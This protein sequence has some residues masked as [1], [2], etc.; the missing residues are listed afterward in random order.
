MRYL[1]FLFVS[2]PVFATES[3]DLSQVLPPNESAYGYSMSDP[4]TDGTIIVQEN[5]GVP[6]YVIVRVPED[7]EFSSHVPG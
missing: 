5:V 1:L 7:S 6:A 2:L 4:Y 3:P